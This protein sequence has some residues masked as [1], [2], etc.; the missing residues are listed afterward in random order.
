MAE[1]KRKDICKT[2]FLFESDAEK[3][4]LKAATQKK[5]PNITKAIFINCFIIIAI[6][7]TLFYSLDKYE[8][9]MI[10]EI[11]GSIVNI[12]SEYINIEVLNKYSSKLKAYDKYDENNKY[13]VLV[14]KK[15]KISKDL[16]NNYKLVDVKDNL[17]GKIKLEEETYNNFIKL[18]E[19]LLKRGYY[20]NITSG[21]RTFYESDSLFNM[22]KTKYE[23]LETAGTSEHN[24][25]LAF[26]FTISK[27]NNK[28]K[29]N[30]ESD[31]YS[32]LKNIAYLYGFIIRYPKDKEKVTGYYYKPDHLRYVGKSIAKYLTKNNL[33]L[34]EY[35]E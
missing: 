2:E 7:V 30:Y 17:Y 23:Y 4:V 10:S 26:D 14:N 29:T 8:K 35:Y 33:T 9:T 3:A 6:V 22:N 19:N 13:L 20:I 31:E 11:K 21:F 28:V 12:K 15:N 34:E 5:K 18:R 16:I 27:S 24:T 25:G 32:Y 1:Y